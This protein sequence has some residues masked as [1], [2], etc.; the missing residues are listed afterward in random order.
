M[1]DLFSWQFSDR[2]LQQKL[3]EQSTFVKQSTAIRA[4]Y[5]SNF[6]QAGQVGHTH[7]GS[8]RRNQWIP[9]T[10]QC[11]WRNLSC[12]QLYSQDNNTSACL[13]TP[14]VTA[15]EG[16]L[17]FHPDQSIV[18][19]TSIELGGADS[20]TQSSKFEPCM[21]NQWHIRALDFPGSLLLFPWKDFIH[22]SRYRMIVRAIGSSDCNIL[23]M[24]YLKRAHKGL[25]LTKFFF[26]HL[27][28]TG[29][30]MNG[31]HLSGP[32]SAIHGSKLV[33]FSR[34]WSHFNLCMARLVV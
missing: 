21:A 30:S 1:Q 27:Q 3:I 4:V 13:N 11:R 5:C 18:N 34:D 19:M 2:L 17:I 15:S 22:H 31:C 12:Q 25:L 7:I 16:L 24:V 10:K 29:F 8:A 26:K 23:S 6:C 14:T 28:I 20:V 9:H 32:K 33:W